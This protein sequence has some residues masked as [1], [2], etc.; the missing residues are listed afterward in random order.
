MTTMTALEAK[1][2]FGQFL[3]A[4]QRS[5]V[6]VTKNGREVGGDVLEGRSGGD[7]AELPL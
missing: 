2:A 7:G 1:N 3:D 4:V 6:T 5:P